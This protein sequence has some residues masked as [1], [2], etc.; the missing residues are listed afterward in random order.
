M[1]EAKTADR[2]LTLEK[3]LGR[4]E[5]IVDRL[6]SGDLELDDALALFREGIGHVREARQVL[7][8]GELEIDRLVEDGQGGVKV[9]PMEPADE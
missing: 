9:E 4:L 5:E 1:S 7:D 6:E 2:P 3:R 8:T